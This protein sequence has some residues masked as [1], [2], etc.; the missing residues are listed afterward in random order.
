[1]NQ[2][3]DST[4]KQVTGSSDI[5]KKLMNIEIFYVYGEAG[6]DIGTINKYVYEV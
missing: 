6:N 1:M 2:V 5:M 3:R 4:I